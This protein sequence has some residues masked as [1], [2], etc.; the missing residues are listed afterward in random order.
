MPA[1]TDGGT[2]WKVLDAVRAQLSSVEGCPTPQVRELAYTLGSDVPPLCWVCPPARGEKVKR[3]TFRETFWDY[4]ALVVLIF[5]GNRNVTGTAAMK[6]RMSIRHDVGHQL[7][8]TKLDGFAEVID[9]DPDPQAAV[10]VQA[11]LGTNYIVSGF[12]MSYRV[13]RVRV[14]KE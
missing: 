1:T 9:F 5:A 2:H 10:D 8:R 14:E 3:H 12:M 11:A 6:A 4:P 13:P 7:C